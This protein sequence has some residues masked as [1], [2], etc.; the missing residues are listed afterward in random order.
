M[1]WTLTLIDPAVF[2]YFISKLY[3]N[4]NK[5][6]TW[7]GRLYQAEIPFNYL[8]SHEQDKKIKRHCSLL[9]HYWLLSDLKCYCMVIGYACFIIFYT[10]SI[11]K[12][13]SVISMSISSFIQYFNV[14]WL[15]KISFLGWKHR[16][17]PVQSPSFEQKF[18]IP[19][20]K[21]T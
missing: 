2:C 21:D 5:S 19:F 17:P 9:L 8:K 7:I 15:K 18:Y 16:K 1:E 6:C 12:E 11:P 14:N 10:L 13:E 3:F 4:T 20:S